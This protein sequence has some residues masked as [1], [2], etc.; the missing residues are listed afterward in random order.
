MK[1]LLAA[2]WTWHLA[3]PESLLLGQWANHPTVRATPKPVCVGHG[4]RPAGCPWGTE[5]ENLEVSGLRKTT[6]RISLGHGRRRAEFLWVTEDD[7][8]DFSGSRKTT[9]RISLG[10][11]RRPAGCLWVTEDGQPDFSG[12][13]KTTSRISLGGGKRARSWM[14]GRAA[15]SRSTTIVPAFSGAEPPELGVLCMKKGRVS[16][17]RRMRKQKR[18]KQSR[19]FLWEQPATGEVA[20]HSDGAVAMTFELRPVSTDLAQ[21]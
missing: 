13:R 18:T 21:V 14:R 9:S 10:H 15:K 11:G 3:P 12:S 20:F 17:F 19:P 8:P 1:L 7:E 5:D 16:F 4:R 6:S 2:Y